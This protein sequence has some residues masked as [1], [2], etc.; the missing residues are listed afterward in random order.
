MIAARNTEDS[1]RN[2]RRWT[3]EPRAWKRP[4]TVTL[5]PDRPHRAQASDLGRVKKATSTLTNPAHKFGCARSAARFAPG[6]RQTAQPIARNHHDRE[7]LDGQIT[8][9]Q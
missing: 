9:S 6:A 4:A 2:P 5:N 7:V 3:A 8:I 1:E